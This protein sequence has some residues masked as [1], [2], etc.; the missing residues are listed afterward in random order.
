MLVVD[1]LPS[2]CR[3]CQPYLFADVLA[4][5]EEGL[6]VEVAPKEAHPATV[7]EL[8]DQTNLTEG[9]SAVH[10]VIVLLS[11]SR[12]VQN[13]CLLIADRLLLALLPL[14][15]DVGTPECLTE[16]IKQ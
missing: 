11:H 10:S 9:L 12:H 8:I 6:C 1:L 4:E 3:L 14:S 2:L 16:V 13:C 7:E 5:L 15:Q